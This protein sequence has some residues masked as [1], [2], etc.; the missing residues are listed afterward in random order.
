MEK[1]EILVGLLTRSRK[2]E[3]KVFKH[4]SPPPLINDAA[5]IIIHKLWEHEEFLHFKVYHFTPSS[6]ANRK[7]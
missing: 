7:I 5:L 6:S 1:G 2:L 3:K 4:K